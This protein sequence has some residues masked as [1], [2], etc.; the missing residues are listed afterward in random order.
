LWSGSIALSV[1]R[2]GYQNGGVPMGRGEGLSGV[3]RQDL[4]LAPG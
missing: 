2:I 1:T 3:I 4:D